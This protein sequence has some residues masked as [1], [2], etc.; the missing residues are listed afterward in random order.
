MKLDNDGHNMFTVV[1]RTVMCRLAHVF[2]DTLR[3]SLGR[4]GIHPRRP[5]ISS[6]VTRDARA[7]VA[8]RL[9][10]SFVPL[11]G[12]NRLIS[13]AP[14]DYRPSGKRLRSIKTYRETWCR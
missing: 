6:I 3:K 5:Y 12:D 1:I 11:H 8:Q 10:R 4:Y 2:V 9:R 13:A 14:D 7:H